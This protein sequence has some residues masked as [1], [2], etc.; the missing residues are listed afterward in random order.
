[1][2][3]LSAIVFVP[4]L[5]A[6]ALLL[7][8]RGNERLVRS[9]ALLGMLLDLVLT[10]MAVQQSN[11][12]AGFQ[13]VERAAWIPR[14]GIEYHLGMDGISLWLV[15][16]TGLLGPIAVLGSWTGITQR[17]REF[18]VLLLLL[19]TGMQGTFLSLDLFLFY[20]FW[21]V[22]LVPMYFLIGIWGHERRLYAAIKF[23]LF[24][25]AGSLLM[26]V[27]I[28]SLVVEHARETGT[29]TFDLLT[30]YGTDIDP[31]HQ[32]WYFAAFALA[33]AIKVPLWPLHTWLPDA[34]VEAPTA[35]SVILAGILL[36]MGGYG[37]LRF[38]MPLFPHGLAA[39]TPLLMA[40]SVIGIVYGALV[41]MVQPDMKKLVAYSSVSHLGFVMLGILSA[42]TQGLEGGI[43]QM[44]NHGLSTGALFLL[45]GMLY[46]RRHSRAIADFGGLAKSMPIYAV[47]LV[48][49][50]LSSIGLPGLNGFVGEFLILLGA[51]KE[52]R[53]HAVIAT[54][55]VVL[56]AVYMLW[57]VERVLFG[58]I[59]QEA[60]RRVHDLSRREILTFAPLLVLIVVMGVYPK[61]FLDRMHGSVGTLIRRVQ[62]DERLAA[63]KAGAPRLQADDDVRLPAATAAAESTASR[64]GAR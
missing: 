55:G 51:F 16:L 40:V 57:M 26:L 22:S 52:S 46:E 47:V 60:N 32:I 34:H 28:L 24:T 36:K 9:V 49:V 19:Q 17:V 42:N 35:G 39:A 13:L 29:Y 3:L 27:A 54:T 20:V 43:Y 1:M 38:A 10:L 21:E 50:T 53:L 31:A 6:V 5:T 62:L 64:E 61:P 59:R 63:D 25:L 30:L 37:F 7:L 33:F 2:P 58:P 14:W 11:N 45:V 12:G 18:H 48:F 15:A 8:P 23:V 41:S 56:G 4:M 44:L